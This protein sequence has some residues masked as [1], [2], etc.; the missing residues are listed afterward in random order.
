MKLRIQDTGYFTTS[1]IN[2]VAVAN[3]AG[4]DGSSS[5]NY[6]ELS[7]KS[8]SRNAGAN[9]DDGVNVGNYTTTDLNFTSFNNTTYDLD[10]FINKNDTTSI[11]YQYNQLTQI[12]RLEKTKGLK[13]IYPSAVADTRKTCIELLS[14]YNGA[15]GVF[16]GTFLPAST[17][18]ISGRVLKVSGLKDDVKSD[19][20]TFKITFECVE[21]VQD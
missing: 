17:P 4:Y 16:Q 1:L 12:M 11:T 13:V 15:N 21:E 9:I 7:V 2:Q 8:I 20:F 14:A 10:C 5:C 18:Y 3:R 6:I 19:K